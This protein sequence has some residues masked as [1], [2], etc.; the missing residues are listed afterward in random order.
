MFR[1]KS[2][3]SIFIKLH[4]YHFALKYLTSKISVIPVQLKIIYIVMN[5]FLVALLLFALASCG[6][7]NG[8]KDHA[9][10]KNV[11]DFGE[12]GMDD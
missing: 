10:G 9:S 2:C 1:G 12:A 4:Q 11:N 3:I 7:F 5:K 6:T 8:D